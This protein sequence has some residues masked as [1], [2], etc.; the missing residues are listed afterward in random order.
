MTG[1]YRS[2]RVSQSRSVCRRVKKSFHLL[3]LFVQENR[4]SESGQQYDAHKGV[5]CE[6]CSVQTTEIIGVNKSMLRDQQRAGSYH[7]CECD[8][9]KSG[10]PE[11]PDQR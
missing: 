11:E 10:N 8:R 5:G 4:A 7:A 3:D 6:E 1:A 9:T 2:G